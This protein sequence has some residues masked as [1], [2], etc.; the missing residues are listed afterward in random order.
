MC[1]CVHEGRGGGAG[2]GRRVLLTHARSSPEAFQFW[3]EDKREK[4][5]GTYEKGKKRKRKWKKIK[6][7]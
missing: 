7:I 2:D 4:E 6:G 1:V 5:T 3:K